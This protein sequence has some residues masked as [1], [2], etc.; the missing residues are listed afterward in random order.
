MACE[1]KLSLMECY[2]ALQM[3]SRGKS[4][5]YF[6]GHFA[7]FSWTQRTWPSQIFG[8]FTTLVSSTQATKSPG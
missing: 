8:A 7:A 4:S 3:F 6:P 1:G 2:E 5:G